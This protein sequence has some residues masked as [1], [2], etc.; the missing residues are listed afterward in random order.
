MDA[1]PN[2]EQGI[3]MRYLWAEMHKLQLY[4][5]H[6][7][8]EDNLGFRVKP[9]LTRL[10]IATAPNTTCFSAELGQMDLVNVPF[11]AFL[12]GSEKRLASSDDQ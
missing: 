6:I 11:A 5:V 3:C 7:F 9:A 2:V 1:G 4:Q 10:T 8:V 12:I